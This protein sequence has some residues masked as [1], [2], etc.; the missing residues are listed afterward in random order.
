MAWNRVDH[1][2]GVAGEAGLSP[3][4]CPGTWNYLPN[5]TTETMELVASTP[6]NPSE[7][8]IGPVQH[9]VQ[10][11]EAAPLDCGHHS[12]CRTAEKGQKK[13]SEVFFNHFSE[14]SVLFPRGLTNQEE[15][16][17]QKLRQ[18]TTGDVP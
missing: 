10:V 3:I 9:P 14:S 17:T 1:K 15:L 18:Q 13:I 16:I 7:G 8:L 4:E 2:T 11:Q 6:A 12:L 5:A